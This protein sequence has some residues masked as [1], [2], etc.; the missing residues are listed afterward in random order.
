VFVFAFILGSF[1]VTKQRNMKIRVRRK[2]HTPK[3]AAPA[4]TTLSFCSTGSNQASK[5]QL[6]LYNLD[7]TTLEAR[8][9]DFVVVAV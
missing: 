2:A 6:T 5:Q 7:L 3:A 4:R 1:D 9:A 8:R